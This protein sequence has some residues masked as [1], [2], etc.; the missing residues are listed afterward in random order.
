MKV[1][2]L[3]AYY[4]AFQYDG[5]LESAVACGLQEDSLSRRKHVDT[6]TG[7]RQFVDKGDWI[8]VNKF[9]KQVVKDI[10]FHSRFEQCEGGV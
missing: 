10:V 1:R 2:S 9:G 4:D 5:T 8:V 3:P 7:H 6:V